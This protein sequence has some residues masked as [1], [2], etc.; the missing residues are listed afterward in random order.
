ME[1]FI[2]D[3]PVPTEPSENK[4]SAKCTC[5]HR[6]SQRPKSS[7]IPEPL[8]STP[9]P[10]T[11]PIDPSS[12]TRANAPN[13]HSSLMQ[14][15]TLSAYHTG[16]PQRSPIKSCSLLNDTENRFDMQNDAYELVN[17]TKKA[18]YLTGSARCTLVTA[19]A[20]AAATNNNNANAN[21]NNTTVTST[22]SKIRFGKSASRLVF[23]SIIFELHSILTKMFFFF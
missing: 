21:T 1:I 5:F 10:P 19:S 7:P 9:S 18:S 4:S 6:Q 11:P 8:S 17:N 2:F 14:T 23:R 16:E 15:A 20:T 22:T 3:R 12:T 13:R